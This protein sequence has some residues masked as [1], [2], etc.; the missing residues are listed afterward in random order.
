[1]AKNKKNKKN[2]KD[3]QEKKCRE[4]INGLATPA[5]IYPV[6]PLPPASL[7][8]RVHFRRLKKIHWI[9]DLNIAF[10]AFLVVVTIFPSIL[11][12]GF[13]VAVFAAD[14]SYPRD[15]I[16]KGD[17][18]VAHSVLAS[19]LHI[20]DLLLMTTGNLRRIDALHVISAVTTEGG[21]TILAAT[22]TGSVETFVFAKDSGTYLVN[23]RIPKLGYIPFVFSL[24]IVK[25][26]VTIFI[27]LLN[28][29][30]RRKPHIY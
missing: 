1:M 17:L 29:R 14:K 20:D 11:L 25:I 18:M 10:V 26:M 2:K 5:P 30:L 22:N 24:L 4:E 13:G 7:E 21:S 3:K 28:W 23:R 12:S 19:Q 27:L 16:V 6:R 8:E 15:S 9:H